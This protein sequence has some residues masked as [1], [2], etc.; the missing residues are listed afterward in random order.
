VPHFSRVLLREKWEFP[1]S[2]LVR[3]FTAVYNCQFHKI[4]RLQGITELA[5][6]YFMPVARLENGNWQHPARL[7][8]G[9]GWIG[10][11]T[12]P[13][14][15]GDV[16]MQ[17]NV[18]LFCNLG[19]ATGCTWAPPQ[20]PWDAVRFAVS[21]PAQLNL[22]GQSSPP[23]SS[24]A[25][26][27]QARTLRLVYVC[28]RD[29]HPIA[30]GELEFDLAQTTWVRRHDDTRIQKMAECFLDSYLKKKA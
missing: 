18:E 29:H 10:H 19:Y 6:P 28:E 17:N 23:Q 12:A 21:A 13:G 7:P 20:R 2:K 27:A 25:T 15:E 11:C 5:C 3:A 9:S 26:E 24:P 30:H 1:N 14:H 16:P 8:L 4:H 22:R